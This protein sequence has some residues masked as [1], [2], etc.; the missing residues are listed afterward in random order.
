MEV[1]MKI[2]AMIG[3]AMLVL[4]GCSSYQGRVGDDSD[5]V[6]G[7]GTA[8]DLPDPSGLNRAKGTNEFGTLPPV[9]ADD[10][11][12]GDNWEPSDTPEY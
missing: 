5:T 8:A 9:P 3:C 12:P 2:A 7:S 6:Y 10:L 1:T 4:A 11:E